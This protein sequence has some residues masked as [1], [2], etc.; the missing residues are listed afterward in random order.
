M[1][2]VL[3]NVVELFHK[4]IC[5]IEEDMI[6]RLMIEDSSKKEDNGILSTGE[7]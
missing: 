5:K 6:D 4:L 2:Q 7:Q 1:H 3:L